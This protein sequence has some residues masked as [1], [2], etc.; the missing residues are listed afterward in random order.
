MQ[1]LNILDNKFSPFNNYSSLTVDVLPTETHNQVIAFDKMP[2]TSLA[3]QLQTTLDL[4]EILT[5]FSVEVARYFDFTGIYFTSPIVR[6]NLRGSRKAKKEYPFELKIN[7]EVIG[8]LCYGSHSP[9][10]MACY[11]VLERLHQCLFYPLRNSLQYYSVMQLAM[12]DALTGLGN[13][14]YFDEQLK[15]ATHNAKRHHS[16]VGLILADLN[17]FKMINDSYGHK[18]GDQ[19]LIEFANVLRHCVRDSDSLFRFGGDEFAILVE[20]AKGNTLNII[21]NR[22][23][24]ALADNAL[25]NRYQL[26]CSLGTTFMSAKDNEHSFFE[27]ADKALYSKK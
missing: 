23:H 27:R 1:T 20:N 11:Q 5:I 3:E 15:R 17:K 19:M 14:R 25:L 7:G 24:L 26:G 13:R 18:T 16:L 9:L 10:S 4:D 2:K 12:Q 21:E 8:T 22:I 6:K